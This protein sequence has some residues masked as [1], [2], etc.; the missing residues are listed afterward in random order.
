M[1]VLLY[2]HKLELYTGL[3]ARE[4]KREEELRAGLEQRTGE[5]EKKVDKRIENYVLKPRPKEVDPVEI[6]HEEREAMRT[7]PNA[8]LICAEHALHFLEN[9]HFLKNSLLLFNAYHY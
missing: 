4:L 1:F 2:K 6:F 9:H 3:R 8:V 7:T 5:S